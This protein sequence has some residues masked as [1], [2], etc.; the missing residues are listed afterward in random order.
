MKTAV[1]NIMQ[2]REDQGHV[3]QCVGYQDLR[4]DLDLE[5]EP[6][7]V[8]FFSKVMERRQRNGWI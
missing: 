7:L 6:E 1:F 3:T 5:Q 2:V 4:I 8:N